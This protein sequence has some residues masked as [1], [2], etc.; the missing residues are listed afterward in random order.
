[1]Q[2]ALFDPGR[3]MLHQDP[4]VLDALRMLVDKALTEEARQYSEGA[5]MALDPK[6]A[7]HDEVDVDTLHVMVSYQWAAQVR[8]AYLFL[9]VMIASLTVVNACLVSPPSSASWQ[10]FRLA[11][12]AFGLILRKCR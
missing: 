10:N 4:S 3:D 5:L 6:A 11:A 12:T 8:D 7:A 1:M 9:C 2:L